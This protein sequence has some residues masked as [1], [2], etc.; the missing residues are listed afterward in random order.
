LCFLLSLLVMMFLFLAA[1][2]AVFSKMMPVRVTGYDDV[3]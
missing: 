3:S 1:A 2:N